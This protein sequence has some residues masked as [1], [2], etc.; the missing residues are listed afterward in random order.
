MSDTTANLALPYILAAQAQKHVTHN[1]ALRLLDGLVQLSV[2]DRDLTAPPS[3]PADGDR[4]I[5]GSGAT[6]D[7]TGWDGDV[8][9][10][11]DGAWFRLRPQTGWRAWVESEQALSVYDGSAWQLLSFA[12]PPRFKAHPA[13]DTPVAVDTWVT[14]PLTQTELNAR[15]VFN[16]AAYRFTAPLA[17]TYAFGATLL[18]KV[19]TSTTARMRGRLLLNGTSEIRGSFAEVSGGHTSGSKTLSL[20]AVAE[21]VAGD[22]VELQAGFRVADGIIASDHT[23]FWAR[24]CS[25]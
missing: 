23:C 12:D 7:W 15:G 14:L 17:G 2:F 18:Y 24:Y 22:T 16:T 9:L 19:A 13:A 11:V 10:R 8:A 20:Q 1:E 4:Y 5:V 25:T 21:L 3:S 6:G